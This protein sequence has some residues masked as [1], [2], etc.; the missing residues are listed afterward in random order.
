M[1]PIPF[2][3]SIENM[4]I[5]DFQAFLSVSKHSSFSKAAE[6]LHI[7]QPAVSKRIAALESHLNTKLFDR[8]GRQIK[9]TEAGQ[10]LERYA[11]RI[12]SELDDSRRTIQNLT[13]EVRGPITIATSHHISLHRLP[14]VLRQYTQLYPEVQLDLSFTDSELA[15]RA[16]EQGDLELAIVTLPS[17][18]TTQL[19]M[20]EL[21]TDTLV[22]AASP[23]HPLRLL[24]KITPKILAKYPAILPP[25]NTYTRE[26]IN[27]ALLMEQ[28]ETKMETHYM[29]TIKMLVSVGMGWSLLPENMLNEELKLQPKKEISV[30]RTLGIVHH[31]RRTLSNAAMSFIELCL[32][33]SYEEADAAAG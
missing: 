32:K 22:L 31:P 12:L 28:L 17:P 3:N 25:R 33:I 8:I 5:E 13:G 30:E 29:E 21:W 10:A 18:D 15:C 6:E 14:P 9:Q 19:T 1:Q 7:T 4:N 2:W 23:E 27:K 11:I 26:L 20:V 16:V 24:D